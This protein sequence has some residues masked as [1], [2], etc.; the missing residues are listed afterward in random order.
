MFLLL[1]MLSFG[2]IENTSEV[3][4]EG[5]EEVYIST[6]RE[7]KEVGF[8]N[9]RK[10]FLPT[11]SVAINPHTEMGIHIP[12]DLSK[13]SNPKIKSIR[14]VMRNESREKIKILIN[15]YAFDF[16]K[17]KIIEKLNKKPITL[18]VARKSRNTLNVEDYL[19]EFPASGVL[20]TFRTVEAPNTVFI[21]CA[22]KSDEIQTPFFYI[23]KQKF[24]KAPHDYP[25]MVGLEVY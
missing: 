8:H 18:E 6:E 12:N 2:Q 5:L 23:N 10:A 9:M 14:T 3:S 24:H 7:V 1:P 13:F 19:M 17:E 21:K 16:E 11:Q 22:K 4:T 15:L 25:L 20:L